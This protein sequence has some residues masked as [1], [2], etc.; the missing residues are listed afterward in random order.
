MMGEVVVR[1][2]RQLQRI[3]VIRSRQAAEAH[4]MEFEEF[5]PAGQDSA[6]SSA[7]FQP[8]EMVTRDQ[9][10]R[11]L[12]NAYDRGFEDGREVTSAML[13]RE[14]GRH[15][16]W[17][18]NFD[19]I[20]G[21]LHRQ[22]SASIAQLEECAVSI[23]VEIAQYILQ[24]EVQS[25][26]SVVVQQVQRAFGR[27]SGM[28]SV[29][30]RL[31][32]YNV[33]ALE[34]VKSSLIARSNGVRSIEII[35]DGA[36]PPGGCVLETAIGNIDARIATQLEQIRADMIEAARST[37]TPRLEDFDFSGN[38]AGSEMPDIPE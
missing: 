38:A 31:H 15:E 19:L 34:H 14:I 7:T 35:A 6:E 2:P 1:I 20:I 8:Q 5:Y 36:M 32:P 23:A 10:E 3:Q 37:K 28:D 16:E 22:F 18:Q 13:E 24:R 12:K 33:E 21:E 27:V 17:L 29:R 25:D 26:T 9:V 11:E 30:V 4:P